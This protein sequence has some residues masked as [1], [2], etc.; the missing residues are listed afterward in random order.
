ML[1]SELDKTEYPLPFSIT[2]NTPRKFYHPNVS[3]IPSKSKKMYINII[4][5]TLNI[6][7]LSF[8][9]NTRRIN[10][11]IFIF[12]WRGMQRAFTLGRRI[13]RQGG[14]FSSLPMTSSIHPINRTFFSQHGDSLDVLQSHVNKSSDTFAVSSDIDSL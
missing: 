14:T 7:L 13:Y 10:F 9:S 8:D 1:E 3:P 2:P 4:I 5:N 11:V 12:S 6:T